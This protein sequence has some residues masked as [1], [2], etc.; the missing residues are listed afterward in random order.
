[1]EKTL[2]KRIQPETIIEEIISS[3]AAWNA[4]SAFATVVL[5]ELRSIER[6]RAKDKRKKRKAEITP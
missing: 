2:N 5:T 6:K 3:E 1:M 4:T